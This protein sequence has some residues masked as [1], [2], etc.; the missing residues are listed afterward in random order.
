MKLK[1]VGFIVIPL[2]YVIFHLNVR[3]F[4]TESFACGVEIN[5]I[6]YNV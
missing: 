1:V 5:I 2:K 4:H 6:P 3:V